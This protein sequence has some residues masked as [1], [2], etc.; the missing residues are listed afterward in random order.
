MK[1]HTEP[2]EV[3]RFKNWVAYRLR[4]DHKIIAEISQPSQILNFSGRQTP[5]LVLSLPKDLPL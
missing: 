3:W 5:A 2:V 4:W 1:R